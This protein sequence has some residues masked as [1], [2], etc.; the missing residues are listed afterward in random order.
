MKYNGEIIEVF[1]LKTYIIR[2]K[3][4]QIIKEFDTL[5][6]AKGYIDLYMK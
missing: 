2:D 6:Q 4:E 3:N 5:E 1:I